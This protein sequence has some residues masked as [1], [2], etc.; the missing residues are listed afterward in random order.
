MIERIAHQFGVAAERGKNVGLDDRV[1][2]PGHT[3]FRT[4]R[5]D[6]AGNDTQIVALKGAKKYFRGHNQP[7][8]NRLARRCFI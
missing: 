7:Q 8:S 5:D 4:R 1:V 3:V 6:H 2:C